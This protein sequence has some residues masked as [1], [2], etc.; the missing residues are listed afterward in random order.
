M[1]QLTKMNT[2][3]ISPRDRIAASI[4]IFKERMATAREELTKKVSVFYQEM[5]K[6]FFDTHPDIK[7][8]K[9]YQYTDYYNDEDTIPFTARTRYPTVVLANGT[10]E[11]YR[12]TKGQDA[13][14]FLA[15]LD[16]DSY[17]ILFG[18][19]VAITLTKDGITTE[20]TEY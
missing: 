5:V 10:E 8:I 20:E 14:D 15:S 13:V 16:Q 19:N 9:W 17:E 18:G 11:D 7:S 4:T 2:A 3:T 12:Y 6:E 1:E